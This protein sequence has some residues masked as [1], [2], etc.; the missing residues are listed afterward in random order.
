MMSLPWLTR[1]GGTA[2]VGGGLAAALWRSRQATE[3]AFK[4]A[5]RSPTFD[6]AVIGGGVVGTSIALN[7]VSLQ[8][9]RSPC[10]PTQPLVCSL[11]RRHILS[12]ASRC[13]PNAAVA[14]AKCVHAVAIF[15]WQRLASALQA[16][17][18]CLS[19]PARTLSLMS[20]LPEIGCAE[21]GPLVPSNTAMHATSRLLSS[22][23]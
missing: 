22:L 18:Q 10:N 20:S 8:P 5:A 14:V 4:R 7:A 19:K 23:R 13:S 17:Q 11:R 2:V 6:L 12:H 16:L 3:D 21:R 1:L 9:L 15:L